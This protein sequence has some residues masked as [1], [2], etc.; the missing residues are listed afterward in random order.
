[1][2]ERRQTNQRETLPEGS[3]NP[4]ILKEGFLK[5]EGKPGDF[6][7]KVTNRWFVL[8][9][10]GSLAYYERKAKPN[11]KLQPLGEIIELSLVTEPVQVRNSGA[12]NSHF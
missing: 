11:E 1:M 4:E 2:L 9:R 5:K 6:F 7:Q 10:N 12:E 3:S 8:L